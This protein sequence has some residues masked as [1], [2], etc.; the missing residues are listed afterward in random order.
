MDN[1]IEWCTGSGSGLINLNIKKDDALDAHHSGPCDVDVAA[2]SNQPYIA[3]QLAAI[4]R[5]LLAKELKEYGAWDDEDLR[6]HA[7]N[8]QRL[9]WLACGD[10]MEGNV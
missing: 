2:L 1:L 10:I 8:L 6:D 3:E 7:Q 4:D 5:A 9:L